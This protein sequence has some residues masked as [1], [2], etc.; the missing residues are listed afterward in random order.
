MTRDLE[1]EGLVR[2]R[3]RAD[4]VDASRVQFDHKRRVVRDQPAERPDFCREEIRSYERTPVRPQKCLPRCRALT[5]RRDALIFKDCG[6]GRPR[7]AMTE[8]LQRAP[9]MQV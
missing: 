5:A 1:H 7:H 3:R 8:I 4:D 9:W 2:M 6:N